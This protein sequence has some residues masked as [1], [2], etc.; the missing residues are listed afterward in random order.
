[1]II[2][3]LIGGLGNQLFQYACGFSLAKQNN[4]ELKIFIDDF[5]NYK[6]HKFSLQNLNVSAKI[7]NNEDLENFLFIKEKKLKFEPIILN[8]KKNVVIEGYWASEKYFYVYRDLLLS[9]FSVLNKLEGKNLEYSNLILNTY[10]ISLHIRRGD[11]VNNSYKDQILEACDMDYYQKA[12]QYFKEFNIDFTFFIFTDDIIWVKENFK[13]DGFKYYFVEHNGTEKNYEDLRL[14]SMCN[15]NI[16][17]NSTFSWWGSWLNTNS[18]KK[19]VAPRKW[20]VSNMQNTT[21]DLIPENW[22]RL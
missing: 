1:M 19:V 14:M 16:I 9:E 3:K 4:T 21:N 12:I 2:T 17:A 20:Y 6:L 10:S 18:N 13:I 7:V 5:K 11:Y 8:T 15:H 22:V